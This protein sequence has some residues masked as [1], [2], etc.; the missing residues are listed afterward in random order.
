MKSVVVLMLSLAAVQSIEIGDAPI[1]EGRL[2]WA[3]QGFEFRG[4]NKDEIYFVDASFS[5]Q[6]TLDRFL[7]SHSTVNANSI[8]IRFHGNV[9]EGVDGLPDR[10]AD[11]VRITDLLSYNATSPARC[12]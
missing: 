3:D 12:K 8:Y 2:S 9:V 6:D 10:Y 7:Q 4:C 1:Y 5:I 11:V